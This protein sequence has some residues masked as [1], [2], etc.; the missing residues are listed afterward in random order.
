MPPRRYLRNGAA[1]L[2]WLLVLLLMAFM[3]TATAAELTEADFKRMKIRELRDFLEDRGLT[4][5]DCQE[6]ADFARY[7]YQNR[8]KKPTSEQGKREVPNAPFWEVWRDIAKEVCEEAVKKRGLDVSA[9]PQS[10]VCSALAYV[11]ESFF[12]QHGKR[13]A[14]KL[15]KKPEALL[16]TSFKA[17][18]YDAGRVLLG[19]LA[20]HCLASAGNQNTCS[21]MSKLM[22][23]T[24]ESKIADLAKW[25]TNV[26]IENTNP[27]YE[28]I[29][30]RDDL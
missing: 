4:C 10:E 21:S 14:G 29:D 13:T 8:D 2:P 6:K 20:D 25:M 3:V 7:A 9:E 16:K 5:P 11:T 30:Q 1:L 18:Y 19:R 23:L 22:A 27:M 15:R 12:L 17:V 28:F 26:G 24:E